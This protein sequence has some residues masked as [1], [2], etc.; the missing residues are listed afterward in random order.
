M[1]IYEQQIL[2]KFQYHLSEEYPH[3]KNNLKQ[4]IHLKVKAKTINF[5]EKKKEK[6]INLYDLRL[7][8]AFLETTSK[9]QMTKEQKINWTSSK[10]KAFLLQ[11]IP[12]RK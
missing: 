6:G 8:N 5:P 11:M 7:G 2:T 4:I 9:A 12:S 10:L 1:H 3:A